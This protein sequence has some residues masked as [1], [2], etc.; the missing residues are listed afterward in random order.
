MPEL[1]PHV[2]IGSQYYV[3]TGDSPEQIRSG[4]G[5]MSRAGLK[6][7]R[8]FLQWTHVEP[9]QDL[10]DWSQYDAL[11]DAAAEG[12]LGVI[13]TLTALHPPGWM[14]ISSGP[15][16]LGPLSVDFLDE[17]D[18]QAGLA[19]GYAALILPGCTALEEASFPALRA[20]VE[21]GGALLADGLCGYKDP[22]GWLWDAG[23]HP[24]NA[25]F[26]AAV[27]DIQAVPEAQTATLEGSALPVWFLKVVLEPQPGGRAMASFPE[28]DLRPAL[29]EAEAGRGRA[30]R[31]GTVFFQHY[32]QHPDPAA[33]APLLSW[34]D[35]PVEPAAL[36]NPSASLRLR[37][38]DLPQGALLV[39]LN[40]GGPATARLR[41]PPGCSL[42]RLAQAGEEPVET[43]SG[44]LEVPLEGQSAAVYRYP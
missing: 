42:T 19:Q 8:I 21:G 11:F 1:D 31:L 25:L 18:L 41:L 38:L 12:G 36:L 7:V 32:F 9:R 17:T 26:Q 27:S 20:Y 35:L 5:A 10:W 13:V 39:L 37:R 29:V 30:L 34:L 23:D 15:Q 40:G 44:L 14:K 4:I 43:A 2:S 6:L 28:P 3:N 24:L 16:D 22:G 33:F